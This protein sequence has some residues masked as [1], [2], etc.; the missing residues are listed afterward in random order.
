MEEKMKKMRNHISGLN[1]FRK[2]AKITTII[3]ILAPFSCLWAD[4]YVTGDTLW[5]GVTK[6]FSENVIVESGGSLTIDSSTIYFHCTTPKEF[7]IRVNGGG[8]LIIQNNSLIRG[9]T[10]DNGAFVYADEGGS[11]HIEA[12]NST[13][14]YIGTAKYPPYLNAWERSGLRLMLTDET[15]GFWKCIIDGSC[16]IA[17]DNQYVSNSLRIE[18]NVFKN[19][20]PGTGIFI[21]RA[22][23]TILVNRNT[24]EEVRTVIYTLFNSHVHFTANTIINCCYPY[25]DLGGYAI[26]IWGGDK[27]YYIAFNKI[28]NAEKNFV[29]NAYDYH[30]SDL[31]TEYNYVNNTLSTAYGH[32]FGLGHDN[33]YRC[34][35]RYNKS[36]ENQSSGGIN[37]SIYG[38]HIRQHFVYENE[39]LKVRAHGLQPCGQSM[40]FRENKFVGTPYYGIPWAG[41]AAI[42]SSNNTPCE[43][44]IFKNLVLDNWEI[45]IQLKQAKDCHFCDIA[46]SNIDDDDIKFEGGNENLKF[47]NIK[48]V[49]AK[50]S[51][52]NP[53]DSF[54]TYWYLD[55][56]VVDLNG[57]PIK[58]AKVE[59]VNEIEP[60]IGPINRKGDW[61]DSFFTEEDGHTPPPGGRH[62]EIYSNTF[63]LEPNTSYEFSA[64][65][66]LIG[67]VSDSN[68][69]KLF[70]ILYELDNSGNPINGH[71]VY[72]KGGEAIDWTEQSIRFTTGDSTAYGRV[73]IFGYGWGD[74]DAWTDD[75]A[76][77][78]DGDTLDLIVNP[79]FEI[80]PG[81]SGSWLSP[82]NWEVF[83]DNTESHSGAYSYRLNF[84]NSYNLWV[85]ND[86]STIAIVDYIQ[87]SS[88][89]REFTYRIKASYEEISDSVMGV[90]PDTLWYR[91]D[92]DSYPGIPEKGTITITLPVE[93]TDKTSLDK[94][95]VYPNPY[96]ADMDWP[97]TIFFDNVPGNVTIRI[98]TITGELIQEIEHES[99]NSIEEWD[100]S[101]IGSGVY[102]YSVKS[103][104]GKKVGKISV[105]K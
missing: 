36:D 26:N 29:I 66:K 76:L 74:H 94:I 13:F 101:D 102:I 77:T 35:W 54:S 98:Y 23:G 14:L 65:F 46:L 33:A 96:R 18:D 15:S 19:I 24:F 57:S 8:S 1:M 95:M 32:V 40:I 51:F 93:I 2:G 20:N 42:P 63:P 58:G 62:Q 68:Y 31:L 105:I 82:D 38:Y 30:T 56:Y 79:G 86:L 80:P 47:I 37:S 78:K 81:S 97:E 83:W 28:F 67:E 60:A 61:V 5:K 75:I 4:V 49:P 45:G 21:T 72:R 99:A 73:E 59:V 89:V 10:A 27:D 69:I 90:N 7:G 87:D 22:T 25:V 52:D 16:G 6:D 84:S 92:P 70:A 39:L 50:V 11:K 55:V 88:E 44:H 71:P 17:Y 100:I 85:P 34:I 3:V 43:G 48:Y 64:W 104:S 53:T 12:H 91:A 103:T 9:E 41:L